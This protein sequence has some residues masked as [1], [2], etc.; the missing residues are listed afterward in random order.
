MTATSCH[1]AARARTTAAHRTR[2]ARGA[3]GRRGARRPRRLEI[4]DQHLCRA[5]GSCPCTRP[6]CSARR[7]SFTSG[8]GVSPSGRRVTSIV[9]PSTEKLTFLLAVDTHLHL[10]GAAASPV[11]AARGRAQRDGHEAREPA[12]SS[13]H[14]AAARGG[15]SRGRTARSSCSVLGLVQGRVGLGDQRRDGR[16]RRPEFRDATG[17]RDAEIQALHVDELEGGD[18]RP[19]ATLGERQHLIER[20]TLHDDRELLAAV[21]GRLVASAAAVA[22]RVRH[23]TQNVVARPGAAG[24]VDLLEVVEVE[25]DERQRRARGGMAFGALREQLLKPAVV[26]KPVSSSVSAWRWSTS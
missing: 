6:R 18:G 1:P 26:R 13:T 25:E 16:H 11:P 9:R 4:A 19:R 8:F 12:A 17:G 15:R 21:A 3:H 14:A 5:S 24:V 22:Q 10:A 20:C 2:H 23:R 7:V